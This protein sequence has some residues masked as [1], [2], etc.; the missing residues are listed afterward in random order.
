MKDWVNTNTGSYKR[1]PYSL[2]DNTWN[3]GPYLAVVRNHLDPQFQGRIAV[4]FLYK[5]SV[6][7]LPKNE[8]GQVICTYLSPF[9]GTTPFEGTSDNDSHEYSQKSYGMWFVPPDVGTKVLVI[10]GEGDRPYWIGCVIDED[11]NFMLPG[12]DVSTTYNN[13]NSDKKLPVG[14]YNRKQDFTGRDST[15]YTKPVNNDL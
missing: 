7:N 10:I 11:V 15:K 3:P 13:E 6:G 12:N 1:S 4:E 14:E 8:A 9:Y 2:V 5:T